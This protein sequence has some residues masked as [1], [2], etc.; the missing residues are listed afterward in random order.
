MNDKI[1]DRLKKLL[2]LAGNNPSAAEAEAAMAKAQAVAIE[3]GIDLAMMGESQSQSESEIIRDEMEFGQR[4]PTVSN[5][6]CNILVKFF[7]VRLIESGNRHFGRKIVFV[8]KREDVLTSKY[9]YTWL[10]ETM[11]RCWHNFYSNTSGVQLAYKQSYL[12]GF[13]KGLDAKLE[14]NMQ[15]VVTEKLLTA[16]DQNKYALAVV[17]L[18]KQIQDFLDN[19]FKNLRQAPGKKVRMDNQSYAKGVSDG[20]NCNIAKGGIG[21]RAIGQLA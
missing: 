4:L 1:I 14:R 15:T 12:L 18:K 9:I 20:S 16:S 19:E 7:N 3:H 2:A 8:G 17:N 10:S 5:Y 21:N 11:V 13:Y 6:V